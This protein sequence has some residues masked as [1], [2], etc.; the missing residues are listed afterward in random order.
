MRPV[1]R[2]FLSACILA[3]SATSLSGCQQGPVA[4]PIPVFAREDTLLGH[5]YW[6]HLADCTS[7]LRK[8]ED[9]KIVDGDVSDLDFRIE[10][11]LMVRPWQCPS[12]KVPGAAI[13]VREKNPVSVLTPVTI[14]FVVHY[15]T[16]D[17]YPTTSSV[18]RELLLEP[19]GKTIK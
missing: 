17:G 4:K 6:I 12:T 5:F 9:F 3:A 7:N 13:L 16:K 11:G 14:S 15:L 8:V 18:T 1:F 10:R 19:L 2:N